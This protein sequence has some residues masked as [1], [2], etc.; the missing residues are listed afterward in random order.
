[1]LCHNSVEF[2]GLARVLAR[3]AVEERGQRLVCRMS[4]RGNQNRLMQGAHAVAGPHARLAAGR[5]LAPHH[6]ALGRKAPGA[7]H[8]LRLPGR[9]GPPAGPQEQQAI[10]AREQADRECLDG[11]EAHDAVMRVCPFR[12]AGGTVIFKI[13]GRICHDDVI[14]QRREIA[15]GPG[16]HQRPTSQPNAVRERGGAPAT[17]A[18]WSACQRCCASLQA[19][20]FRPADRW[21][22]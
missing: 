20:I 5:E 2:V 9:H 15:K 8:L 18:A 14:R 3:D 4:D 22:A 17:L 12:R 16:A 11:I 13:P 19:T 1:M 6:L 21:N 10:A 7:R